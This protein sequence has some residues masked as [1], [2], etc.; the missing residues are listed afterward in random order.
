MALVLKRK[1]ITRLAKKLK[2]IVYGAR[3][4]L[5]PKRIG[6]FQLYSDCVSGKCGL[7]IGGPSNIF[8]AVGLIPIY[9]VIKSLDG[10]NFSHETVWEGKITE[11]AERYLYDTKRH[12]GYQYVRDAVELRGISNGN[13]DFILSSHSIEHIA[14]P[15][16]AISEWLRVLKPGG[17]LLMVVP[18]KDGTFDHRRPITQLQHLIDDF[19][20][21]TTEDDMTH[22]TEIMELHD[23]GLDPAAGDLNSFRQR[24]MKNSEN[25]CFHHHVYNTSVVVQMVDYFR[26]QIVDVQLG[27]PYHIVIL[28]EKMNSVGVDNSPFLSSSAGYKYKSPF[29]SDRVADSTF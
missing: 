29:P 11:G 23:L 22:F 28:A 12:K 13:Y 16:K 1:R 5:F 18:H 8:K 19:D 2:N 10:C 25:R 4:Y 27:L 24:S 21:S 20:R 6:S 15:L 9:Q 3:S 17:F 26:M 7:E 14:N